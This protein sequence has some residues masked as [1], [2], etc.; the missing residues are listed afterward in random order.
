[1]CVVGCCQ[2][3]SHIKGRRAFARVKCTIRCKGCRVGLH[4][5]P[6]FEAY[7]TFRSPYDPDAQSK[8]GM[9]EPGYR[10][11][12]SYRE[13]VQALQGGFLAE[14]ARL[15]AEIADGASSEASEAD[16]HVSDN[17]ASDGARSSDETSV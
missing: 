12:D 3:Q 8:W 7:H 6:C 13:H 9:F 5:F 11:T 1:L 16:D 15:A 10:E 2:A 14:E 4:A 17:E